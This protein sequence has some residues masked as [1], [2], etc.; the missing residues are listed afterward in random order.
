MRCFAKLSVLLAPLVLASVSGCASPNWMMG[1]S[2]EKSAEQSRVDRLLSVA[3][4]YEHD[5]KIDAALRVYQHVLAQDPKNSTARERRDL[6]TQQ[7]AQNTTPGSKA[8]ALPASMEKLA[9]ADEQEHPVASEAQKSEKVAKSSTSSPA[10]TESP[11]AGA[12]KDKIQPVTHTE[13]LDDLPSI[14]PAGGSQAETASHTKAFPEEDLSGVMKKQAPSPANPARDVAV[15]GKPQLPA[16]PQEQD[17]SL[18]TSPFFAEESEAEESWDLAPSTTSIARHESRSDADPW[19]RTDLR[20][21][22]VPQPAPEPL[23]D[24]W[25]GTRLV[26][27]CSQLP[28]DLVPLVKQ[29]SDVDPAQ[30]IE[31]LRQLAILRRN[32]QAASV[33]VFALLEDPHPL[34]SINAA[35]TLHVISGDVWGSVRTLSAKLESKDEKIIRL[36]A[37]L[38]GQMG[39]EAMDAVPALEGVRDHHQGLTRLYAAEALNRIAPADPAG[40]ETLAAALSDSDREIRWFAAVSLGTV[41]GDGE[42]AAAEALMSALHDCEPQVRAAACLSLGG[43][44]NHAAMAIPELERTVG[45]DVP[46]VQTAAETALAC[47]RTEG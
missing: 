28:P 11:I 31:A 44:G 22:G 19:M 8:K 29:L 5:G 20:H 3:D 7:I 6:L 2:S 12:A 17:R 45:Q 15:A 40:V 27:L 35:A 10:K 18:S 9:A 34:V 33:A 16:A 32:A 38:L 24:F 14:R 4:Q 23:E 30:R 39:A 13:S 42:Q 26:T 21:H 41:Q 46:E 47:L 1:H 36:S 37:Y 43:L 25:T